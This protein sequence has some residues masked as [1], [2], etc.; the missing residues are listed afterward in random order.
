M[1][2]IPKTPQQIAQNVAKNLDPKLYEKY[3]QCHLKLEKESTEPGFKST[4]CH[5]KCIDPDVFEVEKQFIKEGFKTKIFGESGCRDC[6]SHAEVFIEISLRMPKSKGQL[7]PNR[8]LG[9]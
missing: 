2:F 8:H 5:F 4:A 1:S 9:I 3:K 6:P 7:Y